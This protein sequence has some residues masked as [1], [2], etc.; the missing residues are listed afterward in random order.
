[1][2]SYQ[3]VGHS[4]NASIYCLDCSAYDEDLA[5]EPEDDEGNPVHPIFAGDE[6]ADVYGEACWCNLLTG[7]IPKKEVCS[8]RKN[9]MF[10]NAQNEHGNVLVDVTCS[11]CGTSGSFYLCATEVN[12]PEED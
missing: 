9:I 6:D 8:H 12:W 7:E 4:Y 1:M 10:A 11:E 2:K 5:D 3:I